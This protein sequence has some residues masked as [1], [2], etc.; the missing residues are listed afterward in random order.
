MESQVTCTYES[1]TVTML[2]SKTGGS[3]GGEKRGRLILWKEAM[4]VLRGKEVVTL[5]HRGA[6]TATVCI[7]RGVPD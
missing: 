6:K 4:K 1:L 2:C 3:E 7:M 5:T